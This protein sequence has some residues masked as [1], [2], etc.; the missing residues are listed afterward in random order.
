MENYKFR[1]QKLLNIRMDKEDESKRKFKEVQKEKIEVE[2]KLIYLQENYKKYS[3]LCDNQ[4]IVEQK[5]KYR[6]LSALNIGINQTSRELESK[7]KLLNNARQE[8]KQ[9][10]IERKT[11]EILKQ[12]GYETFIKEQNSIEQKTND[13]FALYAHIRAMQGR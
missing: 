13:E 1:L 11:V 3:S 2:N 12:K 9:K 8:L 5:I 7:E 4:S 6:Y 10:Q